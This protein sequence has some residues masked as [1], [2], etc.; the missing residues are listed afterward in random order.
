MFLAKSSK[1]NNEEGTKGRPG[2]SPAHSDVPDTTDLPRSTPHMSHEQCHGKPT[3]SAYCPGDSARR[4]Q[5]TTLQVWPGVQECPVSAP[6][7][8]ECLCVPFQPHLSSHLQTM[9]PDSSRVPSDTSPLPCCS[10]SCRTPQ[11]MAPMTI[12]L[13][14]PEPWDHSGPFFAPHL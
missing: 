6:H 13:P 14:W 4:T 9:G 11:T 3:L 2:P 8:W 7:S 5:P 10:P 1:Q 12:Q